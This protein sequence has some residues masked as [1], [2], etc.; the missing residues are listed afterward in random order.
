MPALRGAVLIL[1]ERLRSLS[2]VLRAWA[3]GREH[4]GR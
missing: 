4:V 2:D 3:H 1:S